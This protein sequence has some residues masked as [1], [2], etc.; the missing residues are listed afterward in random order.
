[1][2]NVRN[3]SRTRINKSKTLPFYRC[4]HTM[5]RDSYFF[6]SGRRSRPG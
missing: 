3:Q 2:M 5:G 4:I 1:V 6:S